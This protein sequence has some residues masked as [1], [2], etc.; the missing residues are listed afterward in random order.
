MNRTD[1]SLALV[2][3][4]AHPK[5]WATQVNTLVY[6]DVRLQRP[7][8]LLL[9]PGFNG[10]PNWKNSLCN[11]NSTNLLSSALS[12][13]R[14]RGPSVRMTDLRIQKLPDKEHICLQIA[15]V[16]AV[17]IQGQFHSSPDSLN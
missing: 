4:I 14:D 10:R 13:S 16:V 3:E 15:M 1:L 11:Q 17:R 12:Q 9:V 6:E 5:V 7:S 8:R 2:V